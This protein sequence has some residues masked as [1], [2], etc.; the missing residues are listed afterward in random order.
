MT[1]GLVA[2]RH[3]QFHHSALVDA[4]AS[5]CAHPATAVARRGG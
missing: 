1:L 4:D 3:R 5:T 2:E